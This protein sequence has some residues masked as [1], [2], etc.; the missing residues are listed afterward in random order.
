MALA[1]A[2]EAPSACARAAAKT[3]VRV[4]RST[5]A[6]TC[7]SAASSG[8][9]ANSS[10]TDTQVTPGTRGLDKHGLQRGGERPHAATAASDEANLAVDPRRALAVHQAVAREVSM[11]LQ[12]STSPRTDSTDLANMAVSASSIGNSTMRSTPPA[13]ITTGTPTYM[14]LWP[15]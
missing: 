3:R 11:P 1:V 10:D 7:S 6:S 13:P 12:A 4:A 9:L 14:P 8:G 5:Q 15:Y 2:A